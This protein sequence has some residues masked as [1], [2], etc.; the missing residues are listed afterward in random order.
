M[1]LL[2]PECDTESHDEAPTSELSELS[3]KIVLMVN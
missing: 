2:T 3:L 1:V